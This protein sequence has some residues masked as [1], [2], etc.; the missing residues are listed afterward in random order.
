MALAFAVGFGC[1]VC[2]GGVLLHC[3]LSG[4]LQGA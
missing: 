3:V 2:F 4:G 1:V